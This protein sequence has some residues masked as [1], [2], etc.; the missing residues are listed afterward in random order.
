MWNPQSIQRQRRECALKP[1]YRPRNSVNLWRTCLSWITTRITPIRGTLRLGTLMWQACQGQTFPYARAA[2]PASIRMKMDWNTIRN[3]NLDL[4]L[5]AI[6][7]TDRSFEESLCY[8]GHLEA[9]LRSLILVT[10]Y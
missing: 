9:L 3:L 8:L 6:D 4:A 5:K 10:G 2:G 1:L 7:S